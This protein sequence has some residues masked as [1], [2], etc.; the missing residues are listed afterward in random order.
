MTDDT[1]LPFDLPS[2]PIGLAPPP[3][4]DPLP[5]ELAIVHLEPVL[6]QENYPPNKD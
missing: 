5:L 2:M 1:L 3:A 4:H 6:P